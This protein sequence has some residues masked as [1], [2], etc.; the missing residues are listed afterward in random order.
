MGKFVVS[1]LIGVCVGFGVIWQ[2]SGEGTAV[3]DPATLE[4][5]LIELR[6]LLEIERNAR[7]ELSDELESVRH[8][9][10]VLSSRSFDDGDS[11]GDRPSY[12][13][14]E[15]SPNSIFL[16]A[17][18]V[19]QLLRQQQFDRFVAVGIAPDRAHVI[20]QREEEVEMDALRE[21][22]AATQA[23]A[24]P[25][26]VAR[27]TPLALLRRELGDADY[28]KYLQ[29][30]GRPT[31]ITVREVL[32][33]SPAEMA[34]IKPGDQIIAYNG[35]RAFN[36]DELTRLAL[37]STARTTVPLD[38]IRDGQTIQI[39][40]QSGRIGISEGGEF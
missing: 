12:E 15:P 29:A 24:T 31:S 20:L 7:N 25:Q 32:K 4:K 6:T 40:I 9:M 36:M 26:E 34:G 33:S 22:F 8:S 27:I 13:K 10:A 28:A 19:D 37:E 18:E 38:I 1:L 3:N 35:Q 11:G 23:G 5:R 2:S 39:H 16:G 21:R 14:R 30:R 17:A